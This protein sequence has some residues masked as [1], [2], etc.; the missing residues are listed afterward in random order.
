M[1]QSSL[2]VSPKPVPACQI[3]AIL[4]VVLLYK[5]GTGQTTLT[6][7]GLLYDQTGR[8]V[9]A[10]HEYE[11]FA[12]YWKIDSKNDPISTDAK[13]RLNSLRKNLN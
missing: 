5:K 3:S 2:N 7:L 6:R 10:V 9:D 4:M 8:E 1:K 13:R 11:R 12:E